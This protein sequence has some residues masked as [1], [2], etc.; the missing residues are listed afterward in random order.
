MA[1][2]SGSISTTRQLAETSCGCDDVNGD[3]SVIE[4]YVLLYAVDVATP[5]TPPVLVGT[6]VDYDLSQPYTPVNPVD[7]L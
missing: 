4:R 2:T 6:F 1:G 7:C 5:G 3:G